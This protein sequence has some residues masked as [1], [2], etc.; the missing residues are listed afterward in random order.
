MVIREE[1]MAAFRAE[2]DK[3]F[4][5]KAAQRLRSFFPKHTAFMGPEAVSGIVR[6]GI[7][8]ARKLGF[9][10]E[11][12][13]QTYLSL[14]VYFGSEFDRDPQYAWMRALLTDASPPNERARVDRIIQATGD[15]MAAVA[16]PNHEHIDKA[17][18]VVLDRGPRII[19]DPR[20]PITLESVRALLH[21]VYPEKAPRLTEPG[22]NGLIKSA[23]AVSRRHHLAG[24]EPVILFS[25]LMLFLGTFAY[26]DPQFAW[27][28][29]TLSESE[30]QA[31]APRLEMLIKRCFERLAAWISAG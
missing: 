19:T 4:A 23:H 31:D 6:L 26:E 22:L 15:Y 20:R 5:E 1:Q 24:D 7:A 13:I 12:G 18:A 30:G 10:S 3:A 2:S 29:R 9:K 14:M 21:Q 16:G 17:L 11:R 27:I 25:L 8:R 28:A